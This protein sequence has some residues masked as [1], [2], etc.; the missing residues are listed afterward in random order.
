M[1]PLLIFFIRRFISRRRN[2]P[3]R[4]FDEALRNE[5][6]G[7]FESALLN[8]EKALGEANKAGFIANTIKNRIIEKLKILHTVV[9]YQNNFM[10]AG[11]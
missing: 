3:V 11:K 8:Y 5:N 1:I 4:L 2:V 9:A 10:P 6:S 7:E